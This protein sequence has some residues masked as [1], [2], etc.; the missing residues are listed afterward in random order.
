M[1]DSIQWFQ[2]W[3]AAQLL[4]F[5]AWPLASRIFA[6]APDSGWSFSRTLGLLLSAYLLWLFTVLGLTSINAA[7]AFGAL[8]VVAGGA[9]TWGYRHK[10]HKRLLKAKK[11]ILWETV[12]Y[13]AVFAFWSYLR[14][15]NPDIIGLEKF[16]DLGFM[17]SILRGEIMPPMNHWLGGETINYYYYGHYLAAFYKLISFTAPTFAYNLQMS[18]LMAL[19][20][21]HVF[22]LSAWIYRWMTAENGSNPAMERVAG[23]FSGVFVFGIGNFQYIWHLI[24]KAKDDYWYPN[25][26]RFIDATIHE[27]PLY[28][29]LVNDLHGHVVD[30]PNSLFSFAVGILL[31]KKIRETEFCFDFDKNF[32]LQFRVQKN[33]LGLLL[34]QGF[35]VGGCY[36]TNAWNYP[37][38]LSITGL[39]IWVALGLNAADGDGDEEDTSVLQQMFSAPV[40]VLTG[41]AS[42]L[43]VALSIVIFLPHWISFA[44]IGKGVLLVPAEKSSPLLQYLI[45]W[46]IHGLPCILLWKCVREKNEE[47][48]IERGTRWFLGC[49]LV[50]FT[51]LIAYPEFFYMKDIYPG[52]IR[53]NTMFKFF[54]QAWIWSG[55]L[56]GATLI[57]LINREREK[58]SRLDWLYFALSV[59]LLASGLSYS[60]VGIRQQFDL[61][62]YRRSIEGIRFLE[63]R[64]GDDLAAI[65]WLNEK[66]EGQ[67]VILESVGDSYTENARFSTFTGLPTVINWPVH[68]W[69]WNGS[70]DQSI[71]PKTKV[72]KANSV[73]DSVRQRVEDVKLIYETPNIDEAKRLLRKYSVRYV[74]VGNSERQKYPSMI[75][76]KFGS[77]GRVAF[78]KRSTTVYRLD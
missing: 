70:F 24:A 73:S 35:V 39:W 3:F 65:K 64:Y 28:S 15:F 26:T 8:I 48:G 58:G 22:I 46:V 7:W 12:L 37:I 76:S 27:F 11:W 74:I 68:I 9:W 44:P 57:Y 36:F 47:E 49:I 41:L 38:Y 29:F 31:F 43:L 4:A 53:A 20:F 40:L 50:L 21:C 25:A 67:P 56:C 32:L 59:A 62:S 54:Y 61:N 33:L 10:A 69:L 5:V 63:L 16:M 18:H 75:A 66:V 52:H 71:I 51:V 45:L 55:T 1:D 23:V 78:E 77:M 60:V 19:G 42:I 17:N 13:T 14:G 34:L 72:E 6:S 2:F 30:I